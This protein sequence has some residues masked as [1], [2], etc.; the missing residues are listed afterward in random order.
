MDPMFF[1]VRGA[2]QGSFRATL[3]VTSVLVLSFYNQDGELGHASP[4][5]PTP[6]HAHFLILVIKKMQRWDLPV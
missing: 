2:V 1:T 5:T 4:P 6:T 3:D